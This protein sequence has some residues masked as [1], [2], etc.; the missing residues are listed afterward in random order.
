[1][2]YTSAVGSSP[3]T[4]AG[5]FCAAGPVALVSI[6][7]SSQHQTDERWLQIFD[8]AAAPVTGDVP[9][10]AYPVAAG[11]PGASGRIYREFAV[12]SESGGLL[13]TNGLA[14]GISTTKSTYTPATASEHTVAAVWTRDTNRG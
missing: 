12:G 5:A 13:L 7:A 14:W 10:V 3:G 1:M 9:L 8:K 6:D 11:V 4:V 2:P